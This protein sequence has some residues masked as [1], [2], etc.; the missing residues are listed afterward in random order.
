MDKKRL[1]NRSLCSLVHAFNVNKHGAEHYALPFS[2]GFYSEI[3]NMA[4]AG[5]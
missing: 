2:E 1:F 5:R 4:C 3:I